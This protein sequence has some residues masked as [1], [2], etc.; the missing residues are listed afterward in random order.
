MRD[1]LLAFLDAP[2]APWEIR[3]W[4]LKSGLTEDAAMRLLDAAVAA[5]EARRVGHK[6]APRF[7]RTGIGLRPFAEPPGV[8]RQRARRAVRAT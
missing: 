1:A 8:T 6:F 2:R 5:G 4:G 7:A 3:R